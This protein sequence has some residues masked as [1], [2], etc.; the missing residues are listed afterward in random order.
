MRSRFVL[1]L[2][3]A[4]AAVLIG[5]CQPSPT[6]PVVETKP[7]LEERAVG[8]SELAAI[9][10]LNIAESKATHVTLKNSANTV[11]IFT[12]GGGSVYVNG[13]AIAEVG[14]IETVGGEIRISRSL[15]SLIRSAMRAAPLAVEP[16]EP[17]R[18]G[19]LSGCVVIDAGHGGKDPG[20]TSVLGFYEKGINLAVALKVA[21]L[22][23]DTGLRVEMTRTGDRFVELEE[24]AAIANRLGADLFVSIHSDSFPKASR[25]GYTIYVARSASWSSRKAASSIADSM[26]GTGLNSFG[27]QTAG[28]HVLTETR[29]PA[30]LV[31]MGYLSN[32]QEAAMLRSTSFQD[33]LARAIADGIS[34]YFD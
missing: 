19:R 6:G 25:R 17:P 27:V 11:T 15:V 28:Y 26:A 9:L 12:V 18:P 31:E 30:V 14:E 21:D 23:R 10:G 2:L 33:R 13:K 29:G 3:L 34:G 5:S 8:I 20:A 32:R 16:R 22:L 4:T 7:A 1:I 24:R